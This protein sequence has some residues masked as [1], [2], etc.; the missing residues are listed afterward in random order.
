M[1]SF[2]EGRGKRLSMASSFL[3]GLLFVNEMKRQNLIKK[4]S[5]QIE[6]NLM[7]L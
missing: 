5:L 3:I 6:N 4:D 1:S 2:E 7:K